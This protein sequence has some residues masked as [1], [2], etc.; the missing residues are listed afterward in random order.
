[1]HTMVQGESRIVKYQLRQNHVITLAR[2]ER[3]VTLALEK[4]SGL[5]ISIAVS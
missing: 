4:K 5:I 1:M 3:V 2:K